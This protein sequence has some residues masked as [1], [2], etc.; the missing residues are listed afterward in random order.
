MANPQ[1]PS[2]QVDLSEK[3]VKTEAGNW[4]TGAGAPG[5][6]YFMDE[7]DPFGI[8]TDE[9]ENEITTTK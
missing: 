9:L 5:R 7:A 8:D 3:R 6:T 1:A 4:N 2:E